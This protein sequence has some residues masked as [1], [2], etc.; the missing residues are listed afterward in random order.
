MSRLFSIREASGIRIRIVVKYIMDVI[1][2]IVIRG[3]VI[4]WFLI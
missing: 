3:W 4:G 1:W 2:L